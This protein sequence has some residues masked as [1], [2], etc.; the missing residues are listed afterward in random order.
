[1]PEQGDL[2]GPAIDQH[3]G[4]VHD[5]PGG[6]ATLLAARVGHDA[7]GTELV[8]PALNANI[9]LERAILSSVFLFPFSLLT[10]HRFQDG[11]PRH[12]HGPIQHSTIQAR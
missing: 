7:K 12:H 1:L 10:K 6:A 2:A 4:F 9:R 11:R 3:A 5:L 8:A